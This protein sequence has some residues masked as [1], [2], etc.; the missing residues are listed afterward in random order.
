MTAIGH[1][2]RVPGRAG[3]RPGDVLVVT[4][5]LGGSA[6]GL[7]VLER[8]LAGFDELVRMHLRPP[9]RLDAARDLAYPHHHPRFTIDES[10]LRAGIAVLA[11]VAL[12]TLEAR[13]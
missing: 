4:G 6:A 9:F 2:V 1:S 10:A 11:R 8:G 12:D 7:A 5:P 3:A 13:G